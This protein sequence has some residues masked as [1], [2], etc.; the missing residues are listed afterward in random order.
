MKQTIFETRQ[1]AEELIHEAINI[2]RQSDMNDFL[3]GMENDPVFSLLMTALAYQMNELVTDMEAMKV[4]VL[5]EFAHLLTPYEVGHAVP[6]TAVV[7]AALQ[8]GVAELDVNTQNTFGL[9]GTPYT[10][11]PLLQTR[12][13]NAKIRSV[14]R[15]DGRRWKVSLLFK[16]PISDLSRFSFAV[17][18]SNFQD[19]RV[20]I[21][22]QQV[23]LVKP[24][25]YSE[26]PLSDCFG[27]DTIIY[28]RSQTYQ[29][30]ASSM[31]LFA[32]QNVRMFCIKP[33]AMEKLVPAETE[34]VDLVFEFSGINSQFVFDKSNLVLNPIILVNAQVHKGTLSASSPVLR[35]AGS[36]P[37][38]KEVEQQFLHAVRPSEEQIY[39]NSVIEVR[40]V[41]GDR[42][43]QGRLVKLLYSIVAKYHTDYYAFQDLQGIAGDKSMQA[44]QEIVSRLID[45]AQKDKLH[46]NPGVYILL[47]EGGN[48]RKGNGSVEL[49]YLTTSGSMVNNDLTF[50]STFTVPAGFSAQDTH[51]IV[52]P[53]MGSDEIREESAEA[54][55]SRYYIAT[56]D[57]IVTP[58]DIKLFCY[59]ELLTRYGIVR[60]MVQSISVN[61][62][63]Q[64]DNRECGY[65]IVVDIVLANN[66]FVKRSFSDKASQVEIL[67]QKMIEVRSTNIYPIHLTIHLAS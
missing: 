23:P 13:L 4:E 61:H 20:T 48:I 12:V 56:G 7:E 40:R 65:E 42:F 58:A 5:Q 36:N 41:A 27:I 26:L 33:H 32:R 24:W 19:L 52:N 47:R 46:R 9:E 1:R 45:A 25:D 53:V 6:A 67:L 51:Q 59:N 3:E 44:L 15:L 35:V 10:F 28:N 63:L 21:K 37:S 50:G 39:G 17:M 22:G 31:D 55:L 8:A 11:I 60:D 29:A 2:W 54:S 34:T 16:S 14:V 62:R 66:P 30:S 18:N 43:N 38:D 49:T 57:R 64:A